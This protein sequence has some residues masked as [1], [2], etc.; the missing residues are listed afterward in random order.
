MPKLCG[1]GGGISLQYTS[2]VRKR[3]TD[4]YTTPTEFFDLP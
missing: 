4:S 3:I 1:G 2:A